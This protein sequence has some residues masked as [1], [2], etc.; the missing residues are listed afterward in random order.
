MYLSSFEIHLKDEFRE[1]TQLILFFFGE[2]VKELVGDLSKQI[3]IVF[4]QNSSYQ[5]WF[6]L[7]KAVHLSPHTG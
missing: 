6:E 5:K 3:R 4:F 2:K 7:Q 1:D